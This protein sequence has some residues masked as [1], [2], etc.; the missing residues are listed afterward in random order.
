MKNSVRGKLV[1]VFRAQQAAEMAA[2]PRCPRCGRPL[3]QHVPTRLT[4]W[5]P[6]PDGA[7]ATAGLETATDL[8]LCTCPDPNRGET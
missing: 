6:R 2:A 4:V 8:A 1:D 5:T 3:P 7:C